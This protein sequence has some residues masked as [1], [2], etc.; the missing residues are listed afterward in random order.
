MFPIWKIEQ[1]NILHYVAYNYLPISIIYVHTH[2]FVN[3]FYYIYIYIHRYPGGPTTLVLK[4]ENKSELLAQQ[5][6]QHC[7]TATHQH[8]STPT[9]QYANTAAHQHCNTA[10]R[11]HCNTP[12]LQYANTPTLH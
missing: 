5:P 9:L 12:T 2:P 1:N 7:S 10:V 6:H 3:G 11:Q 8:R 4:K